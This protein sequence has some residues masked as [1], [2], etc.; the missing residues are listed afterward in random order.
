MFDPLSQREKPSVCRG[1]IIFSAGFSLSVF[2][3]VLF[4][5]LAY[6]HKDDQSIVNNIGRLRYLTQNIGLVLLSRR[7]LE[8][9]T[10]NEFY[11]IPDTDSFTAVY[12]ITE[13]LLG[14]S[15][16]ASIP[17]LLDERVKVRLRTWNER[18]HWLDLQRQ[19]L[20]DLSV[21]EIRSIVGEVN[22][23]TQSLDDIV[24]IA[25]QFA[26]GRVQGILS[27]SVI[28]AGVGLLWA[29]ATAWTILKIWN[30]Y[31]A[32]YI[33]LQIV[34]KQQ[35]ALLRASFDVLVPMSTTEPFLVLESDPSL[36]HMVGRPMMGESIRILPNGSK[37]L[38]D[39]DELL[40]C[41][42]QDSLTM[43]MQTYLRRSWLMAL[44]VPRLQVSDLP[45]AHMIRSCWRVGGASADASRP[46]Q[47]LGVELMLVGR[48]RSASDD[49]EA[50]LAVRVLGDA[51][52]A[53]EG[54][55]SASG[56][57]DE[58]AN[59]PESVSLSMTRSETWPAAAL[60]PSPGRRAARADELR[61]RLGQ[62][63]DAM[64][65]GGGLMTS[66]SGLGGTIDPMGLD[67]RGARGTP[68][69]AQ[70]QSLNADLECFAPSQ[71]DSSNQVYHVQQT[72][73]QL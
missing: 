56:D 37:E 20:N 28:R 48:P 27:L 25:A 52:F 64:R 29:G 6:I 60:P 36:D 70:W 61:G 73:L 18:M 66:G 59:G 33:R 3:M 67:A 44:T 34:E 26:E 43:S 41:L 24:D 68:P 47:E 22:N 63:S 38:R 53:G 50:L 39:L 32:T 42:G 13:G 12:T 9:S 4:F 15:T 45:V 40:A 57:A 35:R 30:P 49:G 7:F 62:P 8:E 21:T 5:V 58:E 2:W 1:W 69:K 16:N 54:P 19:R 23:M 72:L 31:V 11:A 46:K 51:D 14:I 10:P 55:L 71:P 65:E 17:E